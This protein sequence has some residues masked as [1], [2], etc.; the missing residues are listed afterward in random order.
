MESAGGFFCCFEVCWVWYLGFVMQGLHEAWW[1]KGEEFEG[2][3][4][5]EL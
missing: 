4:H 3:S 5:S 2:L 1:V